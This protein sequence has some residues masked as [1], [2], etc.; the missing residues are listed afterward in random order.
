MALGRRKD[1]QQEEMFVMAEHLPKAPGHVF[2]RKLNAVL[3]EAGFDR[4][5]EDLCQPYLPR[6]KGGRGFRRAPTSACC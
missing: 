4:W 5:V 6:L 2:F 3:R 1:E